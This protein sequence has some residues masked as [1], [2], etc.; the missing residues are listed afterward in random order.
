MTDN[1]EADPGSGGATLA[2]DDVAG[3][4]YPRMKV[5]LGGDGTASGDMA[6]NA[7]AVGA[8][9]PRVT[10]ASDDPAVALLGAIDTDTGV[11]AGDTT[12]LDGKITACNTGAVVISSGTIT[13]VS[14]VTAITNALPAGNNN[15]GNMDIVT[16]P[17]GANALMVRGTVAAGAA[18][19]QN[20]VLV[21]AQGVSTV[22][23]AVDDGDAVELS[24]DLHGRLITLANCPV[25]ALLSFTTGLTPI[26]D[27]SADTALTHVTGGETLHITGF[28]AMNGHASVDTLV[29]LKE[30]TSGTILKAIWCQAEGGGAALMFNPP[31]RLPVAEKNVEIICGT[32]GASITANVEGFSAP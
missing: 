15:I 11:I 12:S 22:P 27:D 4:H 17:T 10:L 16:G 30:E 9:V 25:E 18:A 14:A 3:V 21:G 32:T 5:A 7:G 2:A 8:T 6:S 1:V 13:T 29:V 23:A 26:T 20:P 19:A 28:S 24:A 31:I